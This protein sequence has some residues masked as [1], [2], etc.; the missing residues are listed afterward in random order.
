MTSIN[1]LLKEEVPSLSPHAPENL[2]GRVKQ[3]LGRFGGRTGKRDRQK[4]T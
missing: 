1:W 3:G 4:D 2:F